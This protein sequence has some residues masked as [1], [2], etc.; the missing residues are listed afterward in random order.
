[1]LS[2]QTTM[3]VADLAMLRLLSGGALPALGSEVAVLSYRRKSAAIGNAQVARSLAQYPPRQIDRPNRGRTAERLSARKFPH[4][5]AA[6]QKS[7]GS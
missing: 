6:M 3:E 7:R 5:L 2:K 1:M 4:S